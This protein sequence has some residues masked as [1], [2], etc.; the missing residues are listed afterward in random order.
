MSETVS[1]TLWTRDSQGEPVLL[2]HV[3]ADRAGGPATIHP[4]E[5]A[6]EEGVARLLEIGVPVRGNRVLHLA[7][8]APFVEAMPQGFRGTFLYAVMDE[9]ET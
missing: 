8:G 4:A 5:G 7:D 1:A 9:T 6:L 2:A 3:R